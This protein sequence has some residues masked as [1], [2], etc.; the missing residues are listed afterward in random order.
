MIA[1]LLALFGAIVTGGATAAAAGT[2]TGTIGMSW[3]SAGAEQN[4]GVRLIAVN[5]R[6][7]S[8]G[9]ASVHCSTADGTA[10]AGRDYAVINRVITWA[11]GDGADKDCNVTI[12]NATPFTGQ[13]I[14]YVKLSNATGA[15]LG[16]VQTVVTIYGDKDGGLVSLSAATYTA[17]QSAGSV[18]ITVNRGSGASGGASVNYA[19]ANGTAIAGT[20]YTSTHGTLSWRNHDAA[21]KSFVIP[22]SAATAFAGG[23]TVAVALAGA[24]GASLGSTKSA[25][26][27]INGTAA[28]PTTTGSATL[29][30]TAPTL[31]ADGSPVSNLTGYN[32]YYGKSPTTLTNVITVNNPASGSHVIGNLASGTWYF[33][34]KAY[35]SQADESALSSIVS[36]TI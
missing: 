4:L 11:S 30:W 13:R 16:T 20:N 9:A 36:K 31:D 3:A 27:T 2:A 24:Q 1:A 22:I 12:S 33:G 23:K 34:I 8:S 35:N 18:T 19:T 21:P 32:I 10:V 26:L 28:A 14:F 6:G 5:R 29:S 7:G 15:P 17:S 25:I